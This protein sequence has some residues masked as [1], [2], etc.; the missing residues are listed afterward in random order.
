MASHLR[1]SPLVLAVVLIAALLVYI[2]LPQEAA[3]E[4]QRGGAT[5][6]TTYQVAEDEFAVIVE[7]LGTARANEAV[8]LTAQQADVVDSI[9]FDDGDKVEQGQLL[10]SLRNREE[11][12]RVNELEVNLSEAKRQLT[13]IR[14]LA[15]ESVASQQLL[16]EQQARV[17]TLKA[18]LEVANTRLGEL[19]LRAPFSGKLGIRQVSVGALVSPGDVITTLDDLAQVK[20]DFSIAETHLPS[21]T[22]GQQ[23]EAR[24]V[25]YPERVFSGKIASIGSRVD[26]VTRAVQVRAIIDNPDLALRPG[27]LLQINLQK[28]VLNT[29]TIPERALVPVEDKQFVYVINQGKA[30][31]R[32]VKVGLRKPGIAQIL[33]GLNEGEQIVVEGTL[34]LRDGAAVS[35]LQASR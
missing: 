30:E 16:D 21:L 33:A 9:N 25:A 24:S 35:V 20:V 6:V 32:E 10:L 31:Q 26:N 1:Y 17:K 34:R 14:N 18:Q 2:N 23:I 3:Q 8:V 27:M 19:E 7:A 28:Q 4:R 15:R 22:E 13:R 5:P 12:A 11:L 29:L